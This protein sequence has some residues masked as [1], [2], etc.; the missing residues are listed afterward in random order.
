[1]QAKPFESLKEQSSLLFPRP[2]KQKSDLA[3]ADV[4][5]EGAGFEP[6]VGY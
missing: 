1:L 4:V 5:A 2:Q 3:V 6:A